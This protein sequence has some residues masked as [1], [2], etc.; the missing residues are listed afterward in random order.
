ML[1]TT[2][3]SAAADT[4]IDSTLVMAYQ[5]THYH[6]NGLQP[7]ML[8]IG[9]VS[10]ELKKLYKESKTKSGTFITACNPHSLPFSELDNQER[11][12]KL[13]HELR[14]RSL[15]FCDAEGTHPNGVWAPEPSFFVLDISLEAAK[16]IGLQFEQNAIVW[17]DADATPQLILL[18]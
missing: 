14:K 8:R 17:C 11:Q 15:R 9:V 3:I 4:T 1:S 18:R 13:S 7:F 5:E 2:T 10:A 16:K 6:V 12:Q